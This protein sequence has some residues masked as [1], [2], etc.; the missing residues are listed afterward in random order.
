M[1]R[2]SVHYDMT[3]TIRSVT[4]INGPEGAGLLLV[5]KPGIAVADVERDE[6][7]SDPPSLED[8]RKFAESHEAPTGLPRC[9]VAKKRGAS[10]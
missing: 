1:V 10:S 3:G 5:P 9:T 8:L 7:D 4:A 2:I 6:L